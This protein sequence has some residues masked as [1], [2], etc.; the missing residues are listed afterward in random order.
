ML[1]FMSQKLTKMTGKGHN[2]QNH[3]FQ[4][5]PMKYL[6]QT[7]ISVRT[8]NLLFKYFTDVSH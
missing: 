4:K 8:R 1:T 6:V 7:Y 3:I 5:D 2:K